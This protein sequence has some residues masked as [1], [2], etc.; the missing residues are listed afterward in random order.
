MTPVEAAKLITM[1]VTA[2]PDGMR[3]LTEQQQAET[4]AIYR[5]FLLD[6]PY[7]A[8]DAGFRRVIASWKPTSAQR[9]PSIAELRG[10]ITLFTSG[11]A[12]PAGEAWGE[13][14]KL[15]SWQTIERWAELDPVLR[16]CIESLGWRVGDVLWRGNVDVQRWRVQ[17]GDNE[18]SDRSKFVELYDQLSSRDTQDRIVGSLAPVPDVR[19]LA[20]PE[21]LSFGDIVGKL[22]PHGDTE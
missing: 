4:R 15:R 2:W 9:W 1:M 18:V 19:R 14:R 21:P 11:R 5:T 16:T 6:L 13:L 8:A 7:D 10:A 17:L 22:L 20:A 12:M 3:W